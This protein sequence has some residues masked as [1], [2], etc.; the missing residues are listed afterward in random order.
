MSSP[1]FLVNPT[2]DAASLGKKLDKRRVGLTSLSLLVLGL[3]FLRYRP[4]HAEDFIYYYCA[5]RSAA[6]GVSPYEAGPYQACMADILGAPNPNGSK[7]TSSVYP[8]PAIFFFRAFAQLPYPL[9]YTLWNAALL[10]ASALLLRATS[11]DPAVWL[12]LLTWPGFV[13]NWTYH[14]LSLILVLAFST[15]L[16]LIDKN[17]QWLGGLLM[18]AL[19]FQP[20]W[21]GAAALYLVARRRWRALAALTGAGVLLFTASPA[22]W[23]TQWTASASF[24]SN[25]LI[26]LDN[27]GLFIALHKT[28]RGVFVISSREFTIARYGTSLALGL[29]AW[30]FAAKKNPEPLGLFL[31][32]VLLAQP[33]S[34]VSDVIWVFPLF[35]VILARLE[36]RFRWTRTQA[37]AAGLLFNA[38]LLLIVGGF[39]PGR[40]HRTEYENRQGYLTCALVALY[41]LAS[42]TRREGSVPHRAAALG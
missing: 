32:L 39:A 16:R 1:T 3:I 19:G 35:L 2:A 29:L 22:G 38:A 11:A 8:P 40:L 15:G 5:G 27:Q 7:D 18:G 42:S 4:L 31:G 33:Y 26:G 20:Q 36:S 24:H 9:A 23:L 14:K 41:A 21:L 28:I 10:L 12:L 25:N 6:M 17:R 30:R 13:S 34:H 37:L